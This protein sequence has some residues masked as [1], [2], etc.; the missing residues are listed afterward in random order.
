M[1]RSVSNLRKGV[2]L[3]VLLFTFLTYPNSRVYAE[4]SVI[5]PPYLSPNWYLNGVHFTSSNEGW[6]VGDDSV[7][8]RGVLLHYYNGIWTAINPPNVS[9]RWG[10]TSV[11]FTSANEGWAVGRSSI[12]VGKGVLLHYYNGNWTSVEPPSFFIPYGL[13]SVYFTSSNEG[14]AVGSCDTGISL[15]TDRGIL[16]HYY[17]GSWTLIESTVPTESHGLY[18]VHFSTP[19]NGWAAGYFIEPDDHVA[20]LLVPYNSSWNFSGFTWVEGLRVPWWLRSVHFTSS[21]EG[22][23]VGFYTDVLGPEYG[24]LIHFL[25]GSW[26]VVSPPNVSSPSFG[27]FG[28]HFTSPSEGWAVGRGTTVPSVFKGVLLRYYNGNWTAIEPPSVSSN[29]DLYGVHFVSPQEGWAVGRDYTNASGVLLKFFSSFTETVSPPTTV[30]GPTSGTTL[31]SYSYTAEGSSSSLGHT[32]EHQFDW[33]GDGTNLS[34]WGSAT[35]SKTWTSIGTYNVRAR[36]RCAID[37]YAISNWSSGLSVSVTAAAEAVSNPTTLGGPTDGNIGTSYTYSTG[38]SSSNFGHDVQYL[39]D[40]GD[41]TYSGWLPVETTTV[42]HSWS[43]SET[44]LIKVQARCATHNEVVSSWF[45]SLSV[46]ISS[47]TFSYSV[48]TNPSGLQIIVDGTTYTAPQTFNW[49]PGSPHTLSAPSSQEGTSGTQ[50]L[51]SSWSDGGTQTHSINAPS[52]SI[53]YTA[54]FTTQAVYAQG[55][56]K[57]PQTGQMKSY[58]RGDD[59]GLRIGVSWPSRRFTPHRDGTVTDNLTGL[60]WTKEANLPGKRM[61]WQEALDYVAG[62]NVGTNSNFGYTDWCL[63]NISELESL[64]NAGTRDLAKWLRGKGFANVQADSYWSSTAYADLP[65]SAMGVNMV[66]GHINVVGGGSLWPVRA[67]QL[68]SSPN[69]FLLLPSTGQTTSHERGD[70]GDLM[71]GVAWPTPRF[72]VEGECVTDSLTGLMW[73]RRP[74]STT[75]DFTTAL[76]YTNN[77]SLCGYSDWR[78]PNR[79]E[80]MSLIN[81]GQVNSTANPTNITWLNAQGFSNIQNF[82]YLSSTTNAGDVSTKWIVTMWDGLSQPHEDY[83]FNIWPVRGGVEGPDLTGNGTSLTQ[84]CRN[85]KSG[86]KCK[87]TGL[88]NVKN[89]GN[90]V[91]PSFIIKFYLSDDGVYNEGDTFLKQLRASNLK[92]GGTVAKKLNHNMELGKTA[93]GKYVIAVLDPDNALLEAD[94]RNNNIAYGPIPQRE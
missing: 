27:L 48:A 94:E 76:T 26:T 12:G 53:T 51:F 83:Y 8:E 21:N 79:K 36:A 37:T 54:N 1:K 32:L 20:G 86:T 9:S 90:K 64:V 87:I 24:A 66:F 2:F 17:N 91:A 93:D 56:I 57:L 16:L 25:N 14:W 58:Y 42:S 23:A 60:M 28:V 75:R 15:Q 39:F 72:S 41:G 88:F 31:M 71:R 10:L 62:M 85:T 35:Q 13:N 50:Y 80:L 18:S 82:P 89:I 3:L 68:G 44:Y 84:S 4:W 43:S 73:V 74:D 33:N 65:G 69:S 49:T 19:N 78:L 7:N 5:S 29:W 77:L 70:D 67:G 47:P 61:T 63:P 34:Q 22:W 52:E 59:G 40:W 38:G 45:G 11:H 46:N 30:S 55:V 81:W 6:A 92:A